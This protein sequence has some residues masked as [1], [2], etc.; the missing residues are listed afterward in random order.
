[1][2]E[3]RAP[4]EDE[5]DRWV[6]EYKGL[7]IWATRNPHTKAWCG[8]VEI[9]EDHPLY[10]HDHHARVF[11]KDRNNISIEHSNPIAVLFE[12]SKDEDDSVGIDIYLQVHGGIT[13]MD[14]A[15]HLIDAPSDVTWCVGFDCAHF[16]DIS[17]YLIERYP[18]LPPLSGAVYR[19]LEFVGR[20]LFFLAD[21]ILDFG[22]AENFICVKSEAKAQADHEDQLRIRLASNQ[23]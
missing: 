18:D 8:Y 19:D 23:G 4:W 1:M 5:P 21:Q 2:D 6:M 7:T 3:F 11:V 14:Y 10:L 20:E 12:A 9:P 15:K 17:P 16:N 22:K 13:Y